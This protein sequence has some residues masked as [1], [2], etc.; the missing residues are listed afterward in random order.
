[1]EKEEEINLIAGRISDEFRKHS[2]GL[3]DWPLIAASKLHSQWTEYFEKKYENALF[4]Q[5]QK[6]EAATIALEKIKDSGTY[7]GAKAIAEITLLKIKQ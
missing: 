4:L 6:L 5:E 3:P 1:M 2:H 7:P